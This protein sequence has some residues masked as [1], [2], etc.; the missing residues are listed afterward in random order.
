MYGQWMAQSEVRTPSYGRVRLGSIAQL[1]PTQLGTHII[2]PPPSN[3]MQVTT[4]LHRC[5]LLSRAMAV[6]SDG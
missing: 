2:A 1:T 4:L 3:D 6:S 5:C